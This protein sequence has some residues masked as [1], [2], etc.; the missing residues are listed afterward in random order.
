M[1]QDITSQPP[2]S[3]AKHGSTHCKIGWHRNGRRAPHRG[4][5]TATVEPIRQRKD[6]DAIKHA[7]AT[8]PRDSAL[9][10]VG[11][12]F[13]LRGSDL[14]ALRW[15][16]V[17]DS[18]TGVR[19]RVEVCEKKTGKRRSIVVQPN[20]KVALTAW[21]AVQQPAQKALVFPSFK[22]GALTIQRL[23]QL[24]NEWTRQVGSE[25]NFGSHTLRKTFGYQL[26]QHGVGIETI[27]KIYGH[28]SQSVTMRYLGIDRDETDQARL[29]LNL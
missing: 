28:T 19:V 10:I 11:I 8:R 24:V 13:G 21:H 9:F 15:D 5:G 3:L 6:I 29:M 25:G 20:A 4:I 1:Q 2:S 22:G 26:R 7:L 18:A 12:H 14:L 17:W 16:D 23:H 27:M